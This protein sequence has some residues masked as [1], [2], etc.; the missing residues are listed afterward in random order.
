MLMRL[1]EAANYSSPHSDID[2]TLDTTSDKSGHPDSS[3]MVHND[4][5]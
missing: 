4:L 2:S 5:E 1:Q 3:G